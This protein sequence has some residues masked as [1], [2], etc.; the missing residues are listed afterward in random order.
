MAKIRDLYATLFL[1]ALSVVGITSTVRD[2]N[3]YYDKTVVRVTRPEDVQKLRD[4]MMVEISLPLDVKKAYPIE[5]I[6]SKDQMQLIPFAGVGYQLMWVVPGEMNEREM[7]RL[8]PPF[9][10]RVVEEDGLSWDVYGK[11]LKLKTLFF[12]KGIRLPANTLVV[13][14]APKE[15]LKPGHLLIFVCA[16]G[17]LV[18]KGISFIRWLMR[19]G[20]VVG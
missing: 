3:F 11:R 17:Y 2:L 19:R 5:F 7:A 9:K 6:V 4:N 16:I 20:E 1:I 10:G 8:Q 13:Y 14:D 18:W 12:E 15:F